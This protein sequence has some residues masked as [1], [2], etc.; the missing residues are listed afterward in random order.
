MNL[1]T[2]MDRQLNHHLLPA[3]RRPLHW[4][5]FSRSLKPVLSVASG[6]FVTIETLTQRCVRLL[7]RTPQ[8][9]N[10]GQRS[11]RQ[12]RIEASLGIG[13]AAADQGIIPTWSIKRA[14]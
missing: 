2:S 6:D 4:G 11:I 8:G 7:G 12:S 9:L 13:I 3:H 1:S 5:F 10:G 14:G